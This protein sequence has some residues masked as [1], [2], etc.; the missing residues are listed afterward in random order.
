MSFYSSDCPFIRFTRP[1]MGTLVMTIGI[2][3]CTLIYYVFTLIDPTSNP[4]FSD[5]PINIYLH[6]AL[7]ALLDI[8]ISVINSFAI[9]ENSGSISV[10]FRCFDLLFIIIIENVFVEPIHYAYQWVSLGI[11]L[12]GNILVTIGVAVGIEG[13]PKLLT[14]ILLLFAQLFM[15]IRSVLTQRILHNNDVSPW[16]LTGINGIY[17]F[18]LVLFGFYPIAN[19]LPAYSFKSLHENFCSSVLL[20][21]HSTSLIILFLI[22]IPISFTYN[23][24]ITGTLMTTNAVG[25][26]IFEMISGAAGWIIDLIIYHAFHGKFILKADEKFGTKWDRYSFFRLFGSLIFLM[27]GAMYLKVYRF[28]CFKYPTASVTKIEMSTDSSFELNFKIPL[29]V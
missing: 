5:I 14:S 18:F 3:A 12:I 15:S 7:L 27:G 2:A 17:G 4:K 25:Y 26:T 22:Y 29:N 11:V 24:C 21:V 10:A 19:F 13:K 23:V 20:T 9:A 1:W 8:L 6:I 28:S 16:L